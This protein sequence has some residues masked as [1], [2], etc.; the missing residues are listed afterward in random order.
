MMLIHQ[1][2]NPVC[3]FHRADQDQ[4]DTDRMVILIGPQTRWSAPS[5]SSVRYYD[6]VWRDAHTA[7]VMILQLGSVWLESPYQ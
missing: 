2:A 6:G 4:P 1:G 7:G 3:V 5:V